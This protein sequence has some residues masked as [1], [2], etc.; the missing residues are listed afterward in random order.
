MLQLKSLNKNSFNYYKILNS[1]IKCENEI[2]H[3]NF[4]DV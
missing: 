1:W 2:H 3:I 4:C